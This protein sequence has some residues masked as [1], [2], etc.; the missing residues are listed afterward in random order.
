MATLSFAAGQ[1]KPAYDKTLAEAP[2]KRKQATNQIFPLLTGQIRIFKLCRK[3]RCR[4]QYLSRMLQII[5]VT[6]SDGRIVLINAQ[7]E[8]LFGYAREELVGQWVET[9]VPG[10]YRR[11]HRFG[12]LPHHV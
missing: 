4:S 8:K 3:L 11:E 1:L 6:D 5:E 2:E 12:A 10:R 9:L 7:T